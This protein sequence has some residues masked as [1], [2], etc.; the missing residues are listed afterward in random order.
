VLLTPAQVVIDAAL[1][2]MSD[3]SCQSTC[4]MLWSLA[5]G[6]S[7]PRAAL[8][9][10]LSARLHGL[11]DGASAQ[12]MGG[13]A[14]CWAIAARSIE[15][16]LVRTGHLK[17]P[18][19]RPGTASRKWITQ[20]VTRRD[21]H[22]HLSACCRQPIWTVVSRAQTANKR[23]EAAYHRAGNA[24]WAFAK[25]GHSPGA[26]LLAAAAP[27]LTALLPGA[28]PQN[29]ANWL[30]PYVTFR[31]EPP[32]QLLDGVVALIEASPEVRPSRLTP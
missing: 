12:Q 6:G 24:L 8:L 16:L 15:S 3:F 32:A 1:G 27:R 17:R 28:T 23:D 21:D 29:V 11:M 10:A 5:T 9:D 18:Q 4:N 7:K 26:G 25:L 19:T 20:S 14:S 2:C 31:A 30:L 22:V 13:T